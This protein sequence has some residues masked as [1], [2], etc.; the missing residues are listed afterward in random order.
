MNPMKTKWIDMRME[1]SAV[2]EGTVDDLINALEVFSIPFGYEC[3]LS[4]NRGECYLA[5][6]GEN[7]ITNIQQTREFAA[8]CESIGI[9]EIVAKGI[10]TPRDNEDFELVDYI[11][12]M[13]ELPTNEEESIAIF[14]KL[15]V[16]VYGA[17]EGE[18][19]NLLRPL[20]LATVKSCR[21]Q[22]ANFVELSNRN[23]DLYYSEMIS[24]ELESGYASKLLMTF[25][26]AAPLH[27][28]GDMQVD[29]TI[30]AFD[31]EGKNPQNNLVGNVVLAL[32]SKENVKIDGKSKTVEAFVP[33]G[34][35]NA[36]RGFTP[37]AKRRML[38]Y[39]MDHAI[40]PGYKDGYLLIDPI[41]AQLTLNVSFKGFAK[42]ENQPIYEYYTEMRK[43]KGDKLPKPA[44]YEK[45]I[46]K[47]EP[48]ELKYERI[49]IPTFTD[50]VPVRTYLR[51]VGK[52]KLPLLK[53]PVITSLGTTIDG[54][55]DMF[56]KS[57]IR[58]SVKESFSL[59]VPLSQLKKNGPEPPTKEL[60]L[61]GPMEVSDLLN[62]SLNP[63]TDNWTAHRQKV[64][65]EF[66]QDAF[67]GTAF[68]TFQMDDPEDRRKAIHMDGW[69]RRFDKYKGV[70]AIAGKLSS[71][72]KWHIQ[73]IR[74]PKKY[75]LRRNRKEMKLDKEEPPQW[76]IELR[77]NT[78]PFGTKNNPIIPRD[79]MEAFDAGGPTPLVGDSANNPYA[80]FERKS[81]A[82]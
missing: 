63:P 33:V 8:Y 57:K 5:V 68:R 10:L 13:E 14:S 66:D 23:S 82:R 37:E 26:N 17:L 75:N 38:D 47:L 76:Y 59:Q 73:S 32:I 48:T 43:F 65:W 11:V 46:G 79:Y 55:D 53:N 29:A 80:P 12:D 9:R 49:K 67:D 45:G 60:D 30:I 35:T 6:N 64:P 71:T 54:L 56:E 78:K 2:K 44:F 70:Q 39:L 19:F 22:S 27:L 42:Q 40:Q 51:E 36:F 20:A 41:R 16:R 50:A 1:T 3:I 7:A 28:Y 58:Y 31:I 4:Y 18:D 15:E 52:K 81:S 21:S 24:D 77:P 34:I 69:K 61:P 74:V 72:G 62:L 25:E